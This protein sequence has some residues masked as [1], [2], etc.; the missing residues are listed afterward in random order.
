[1]TAPTHTPP[2]RPR[3][4]T[5]R[6][7]IAAGLL[8]AGLAIAACSSD[9]GD[10]DSQ[11][12]LP[13]LV[14]D[15]PTTVPDGVDGSDSEAEPSDGE[16]AVSDG[17]TNPELA[18]L[19]AVTGPYS[20]IA[21]EL[22]VQATE[23][24]QVEVTA[25]AG[26]HVVEVPR[27]A[28]FEPNHVVP[29]VGMRAERE[30]TIDTELFDESGS[31]LGTAT[32]SFTTGALP[33]WFSEF[34]FEADPAR[35]SPGVTIIEVND[36][37]PPENSPSAQYLIGVDGA[38]EVVWY[39]QNNG[40]VGA[41]EMTPDGT[42]VSHYWPFGAR[43]FDVLG[44]V[45]GNWQFLPSDVTDPE[46]IDAEEQAEVIDEDLL[47]RPLSSI[48]GNPGDPPPIPVWADHVDLVTFHHEVWPMP[49]GNLL[50][51]STTAHDLTPEQRAAFCPDDP[52]E[53]GVVS[54]VMVE[55]ERSGRVVRTWDLWDVLD[56]DEVPGREL[57]VLDG[58]FASEG[59]RD[60]THG[61]AA[62][63]D[64]ERDAI[65][66]S[67]RHTNQV[68]AFKHL[69]D[70][71]PQTELLWT[72]G[73]VGTIPL[74]GDAPYYQHAVEVQDDGSILLYDNGN[75]R[76]GTTPDDPDAPTYS[77]AVIYDVDDT[78]D[79]PAE[80]SATQR[81]EHR[82]D[83]VDDAALFARFLGDADRLDN[84]NVL[85]AHGGIDP[86]P[87]YRHALIIEV[88]PDGVSGG[89]IVWRFEIGTPDDEHTVYRA[90]RVPSLYAGP[91]WIERG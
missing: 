67:S 2:F 55:F 79:D 23:P 19:T 5:R 7:H 83:D 59:L 40:V 25:T 30:Y 52:E 51:M 27:T 16:D 57:C 48:D 46:Q 34:E 88:E 22:T 28:A 69:D 63:Y 86:D 53:F 37:D 65:I 6:C 90:E 73:E 75:F 81:W 62:V 66:V 18:L 68:V 20:S 10:G 38:G 91:D 17:G 11:E 54:D 39:Y 41:V 71:G 36:A 47:N 78:S 14:G 43:E 64:E 70:E 76:P 77:R 49:N 12:T 31:S 24:V 35:S 29:I 44:N 87:G 61:N 13:A 89:D 26:D 42:F 80:W 15:A 72:F 32:T 9:D 60:W 1:M 33:D 56:I 3:R 21:A 45:S 58:F 74:E 50:T 82:T 8:A 84:G 4:A 85:I